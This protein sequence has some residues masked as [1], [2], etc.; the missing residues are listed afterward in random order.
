[1]DDS[2]L[3]EDPP[4]DCPHVCQDA[5]EAEEEWEDEGE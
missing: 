4:V 2:D 5:Y 1:M 3:G